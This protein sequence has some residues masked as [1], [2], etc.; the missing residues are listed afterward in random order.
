[1][2]KLNTSKVS[3]EMESEEEN[4]KDKPI[5]LEE[6]ESNIVPA[7]SHSIPAQRGLVYFLSGVSKMLRESW[8]NALLI[9]VP[10]ALAGNCWEPTVTFILCIIAVIPLAKLLGNATE[11]LALHTSQTIGGLL[12]ATFGNAIELIVGII[13]L[14]KGML[15]VVQST[16]LGS[17][18]SNLLLVL[19]MAFCSAGIR[20]KSCRFN[21]TAAQTSSSLLLL[22]V[23]GLLIPAAFFL[24]VDPLHLD[25]SR[26]ALSRATALL[27]VLV[28]FGYLYFQLRTHADLFEDPAGDG[29][30]EA[31]APCMPVWGAC[32]LL[33]AA[34][35][36]VS[37]VSDLLVGSLESIAASW[38]VS[39]TFLALVV[40]PIVGNAAEHV[41]SVTVAYKGKASL[42][43]GIA[44]GS[45]LQIALM[46]LPA[47]V[48]IGWAIA[49]PLTMD[50]GEFKTAVCLLAVI[51]VNAV[52][53]ARPAP[54]SSPSISPSHC[55]P[56]SYTESE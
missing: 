35:V 23:M 26:L 51:I 43:I 15:I 30:A 38:G 1:M 6:S 22:A 49:Q 56:F 42:A 8:I 11:E 53:Q 27:L 39:E 54:R 48:L 33:L 17:I 52:I 4:V 25:D 37:V 50:F 41:S 13:A 16:C 10:F 3:C 14:R 20:F 32:A 47:L 5:L 24:T 46:V 29:D 55:L 7:A 28:Y 12:N 21:S 44:V 31:E 18:L 2:E 40:I 45:S 34:T 36:V 19:G 9:A